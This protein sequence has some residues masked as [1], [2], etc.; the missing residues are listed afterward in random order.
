M[1]KLE[2][3]VEL[4]Q[5][6]IGTNLIKNFV[7]PLP[8]LAE[9]E[10]IVAKIEELFSELDAGIESLKT[11]QAQLKIYRQAV[12]KYAFEGK[13]TNENVNEG[14]LPKGWKMG[15]IRRCRRENY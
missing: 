3:D 15:K 10:R 5:A 9:Q 13:L 1:T 7:F 14:E 2:S 4:L 8:P 12:L 6:N 11:A